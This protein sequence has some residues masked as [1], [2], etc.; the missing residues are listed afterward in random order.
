MILAPLSWPSNPTFATTTRTVSA[1][2]PPF[3]RLLVFS[4]QFLVFSSLVATL[5]NLPIPTAQLIT[6]Y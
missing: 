6:D 1:T 3:G 2:V 5:H 4:S